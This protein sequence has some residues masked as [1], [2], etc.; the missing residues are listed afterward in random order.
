[1]LGGL[2]EVAEASEVG[3]RVDLEAI[4]VRAEVRA[5]CGQVGIDPYTSISEGTLIA[6]VVNEGA[7][8]FVAALA[9]EGI[10]SAV[11][12]EVVE[13]SAGSVLVTSEGERQLGHPGPDPFWEAFG[14]WA[15][16][17]AA[18]VTS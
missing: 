6:T 5:V 10:A 3:V 8:A 11:V 1:M 15:Q 7:E 17:A 13:R 14:R 9:A 2:V 12:G 18:G 4:P 16:E